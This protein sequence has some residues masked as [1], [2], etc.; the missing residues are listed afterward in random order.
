MVSAVASGLFQYPR[1]SIGP[2]KQISPTSPTGSAAPSGPAIL[3][4]IGGTHRP[5]LLGL[6]T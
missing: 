2:E 6:R 4:S 5:V 1:I 3:M